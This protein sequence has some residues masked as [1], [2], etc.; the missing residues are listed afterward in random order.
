MNNKNYITKYFIIILP[1]LFINL[2]AQDK[3]DPLEN[4]IVVEEATAEE[5]KSIEANPEEVEVAEEA[6]EVEEFVVKES[7]GYSINLYAGYPVIN[8]AT[9]EGKDAKPVLGVSIGTPFGFTLGPLFANVGIELLN[10]GFESDGVTA[11]GGTAFLGGIN[12]GLEYKGYS[13][14]ATATT[15]SFAD[16][17]GFIFGGNVVLPVGGGLPVTVRGSVRANIIQKPDTGH[18]DYTGWF[19]GG[20]SMIDFDKDGYIDILGSTYFGEPRISI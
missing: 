14:S 15:G 17:S 16:G 9:T 6:D 5:T 1:L 11:L 13:I 8:S 19:G 18:G 20:V 4:E 2:N 7:L 10:Y 3:V 12:T